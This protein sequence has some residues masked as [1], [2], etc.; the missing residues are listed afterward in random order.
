MQRRQFI[1]QTGITV[2][3][4]SALG[5]IQWKSGQFVGDNPTTTD[6][7][8][9]FYRPGAPYRKNLNPLGFAG[10]VLHLKG[11]LLQA[12]AKT[13]VRDGLI[14]IWQCQADGLYD[15]V[16]DDYL[17]RAAQKIR[18]NGQYHFITTQPVAYPVEENSPIYRPAHIHMRIS[19]KGHQDLITQ[20]YFTGDPYLS[21]DPSTKSSLAAK[22]IL[23][24]N[25]KANNESEIT[26]DIILQKEYLPDEA[27]FHKVSGIYKM[28]DKSLMEFYRQGDLLF[29]KTNNQIW[30]GLH[31]TGNN[32]FIGGVNDTSATFELLP[33]G[34]AKV[35]FQFIR[36]RETRIE[37]IKTLRYK[38]PT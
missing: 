33:N 34:G 13:L 21:S 18:A 31:Y 26:F 8:G 24:I 25:K 10:E 19:V 35:Q 32:T 6:I 29:Y 38:N 27:L 37:G 17:Y 7:L 14:E 3:G 30:G 12:D 5:N 28:S 4:I 23:Q 36:R 20:I 2:L 15:N 22:R 9:P 11:K 1:K 16:S